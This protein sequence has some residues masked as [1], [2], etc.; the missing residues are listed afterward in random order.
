MENSLRQSILKT[1]LYADIFE[2]PLTSSQIWRYL[3]ASRKFK[4]QDFDKALKDMGKTVSSRSGLY[5]LGSRKK[6]I[7]KR[8]IRKKESGKKFSS[9]YKAAALLSFIPTV[10]LIGVS[11]GLSME[12]ADKKDDID[13]FVIT[14]SNRLWTTRIFIILILK[15]IGKHRSRTGKKVTDKICLNMLVDEKNLS[16]VKRKDLYTAHEI[17]QMVPVFD[18]NKTYVRFVNANLWVKKFMPNS[19]LGINNLPA[20]LAEAS[21]KRAGKAGKELS[22]KKENSSF[23]INHSSFILEFF[24]KNIQLWY[25]KKHK[26]IETVTDGVLAFHPLDYKQNIMEAYLARIKKYGTEI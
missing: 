26:S 2:Y 15:I 18:R 21:A 11:G 12:N 16:F 13:I 24:A 14:R 25:I 7:E 4:K 19:L 9:L 5:F 3:I 8:V 10:S 23:I 1:V 22:I 6:L 17:A 20:N